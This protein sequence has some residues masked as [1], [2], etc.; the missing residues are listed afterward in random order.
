MGRQVVIAAGGNAFELRPAKGKLVLDVKGAAGVMCQL[1]L[2][3]LPQPQAF[4][5]DPE[6]EIPLEPLFFPEV[7]PGHLLGGRHEEFELHLLELAKPEDR[8]A[9]CDLVAKRLADLRDTE[10]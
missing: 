7:E 5:I 1:V 9:G 2:A 4:A 10:A 3:V 6:P 8:V